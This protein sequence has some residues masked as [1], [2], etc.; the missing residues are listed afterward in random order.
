MGGN[1]SLRLPL[2]LYEELE[3]VADQTGVSVSDVARIALSEGLS[4][5]HASIERAIDDAQRSG[6]TPL[7]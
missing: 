4:A 5:A 3:I 1:L 6:G 7:S 2:K